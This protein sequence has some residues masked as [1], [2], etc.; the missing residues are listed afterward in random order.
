MTSA[1]YFLFISVLYLYLVKHVR[2]QTDNLTTQAHLHTSAEIKDLYLLGLFP[3]TG[4]WTGGYAI[5]PAA[6]MAVDHI[7]ADPNILQGYRL[8]LLWNDTQVRFICSMQN[9]KRQNIQNVQ[10]EAWW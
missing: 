9:Q 10:G 2:G 4:A 6:L 8:N 7:N 5:L 1:V 3:I